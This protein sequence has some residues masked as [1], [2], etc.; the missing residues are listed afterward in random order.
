MST[1]PFF[2]N[3]TDILDTHRARRKSHYPKRKNKSFLAQKEKRKEVDQTAKQAGMRSVQ[4]EAFLSS[5]IKK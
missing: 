2:S 5:L 3:G 4:S 1:N